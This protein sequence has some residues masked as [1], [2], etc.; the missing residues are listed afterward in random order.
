MDNERNPNLVEYISTT[1]VDMLRS[2]RELIEPSQLDMQREA[3][4]YGDEYAR[5][6]AQKDR[7][8]VYSRCI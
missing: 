2:Q 1:N 3:L 8:S 5:E 6:H 4:Q 7:K